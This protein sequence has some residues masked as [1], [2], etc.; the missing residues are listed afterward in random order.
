MKLLQIQLGL[1]LQKEECQKMLLRSFMFLCSETWKPC[2]AIFQVYGTHQA[3][4]VDLLY[5]SR[6]LVQRRNLRLKNFR[7]N[8]ILSQA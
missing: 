8:W 7:L 6:G 4:R 3:R 1:W 5:Y 2:V